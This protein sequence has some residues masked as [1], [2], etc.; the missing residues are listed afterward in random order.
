[1]GLTN[2]MIVWKSV[3]DWILNEKNFR[4]NFTGTRGDHTFKVRNDIVVNKPRINNTKGTIYI[5]DA[6]IESEGHF[7]AYEKKG[8]HI[9]VF[10]PASN[11]SKTE[12]G[13]WYKSVAAHV[14]SCSKSS[15]CSLYPCG[16]QRH[17]E[18]TFCQTW[19]VAWLH[20]NMRQFTNSV[21]TMNQSIDGLYHICK[22][23]SNSTEFERFVRGRDAQLRNFITETIEDLISDRKKAYRARY[24]KELPKKY[25][26]EYNSIFR[27]ADG[28]L[29]YSRLFTSSLSS[30]K[31]FFT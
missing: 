8:K 1:M 30:F 15:T 10:D 22:Y 29:R 4:T 21:K 6:N 16:P 25:I 18:D 3:W 23:I 31:K 2:E 7:V 5:A 26:D 13:V 27:D 12:Y 14:P 17:K 19:T 24:K 20:P 28:F 9:T 11:N